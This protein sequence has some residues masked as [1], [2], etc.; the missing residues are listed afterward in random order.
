MK[1]NIQGICFGIGAGWDSAS[2]LACEQMEKHTGILCTPI[3]FVPRKAPGQWNPSWWKMCAF[4]L[5]NDSTDYVL[6][7]DADI[8]CIRDW[9]PY[10]HDAPFM[11]VR[12]FHSA[13]RAIEAKNYQV[14]DYFNGGFFV[15]HRSMQDRLESLRDYG[16][17]YGS[18]LEQTALN[19]IFADVWKPLPSQCN[20]LIEEETRGLQGAIDSLAA[21]LH[22]AG[23]KDPNQIINYMQKIR[24]VTKQ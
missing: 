11:A 19:Q 8:V 3:N 12:E 21:N 13:T 15:I 20:W 17:R 2:K 10:L 16:P 24:E 14:R 4:D 23:T 9:T 5:V 1:K 7:F 6:V 18:W 22:L